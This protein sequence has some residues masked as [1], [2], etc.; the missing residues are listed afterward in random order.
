MSTGRSVYGGNKSFWLLSIFLLLMVMLL[1]LC[2]GRYH[3]PIDKVLSILA[4]SLFPQQWLTSLVPY[5]PIEQRVVEYIR[6]P[7]MLIALLTGAGLSVAGAALQGIFRN[8]LVGPQMVGVSSGAALGGALGIVLF[9]SLLVVSGLAFIGGFG[10]ILLVYFLSRSGGSTS[11][12]MLILAG[13]VISAFF[14]A[15]ISLVTYFADPNNTLPAIVFWLMGSF[16]TVTYTKLALATLPVFCGL[17]LLYAL[18]FR[19]NVLSLGD[20]NAAALGVPVEKVRWLVLICVALIT[21]ATVAVA[22]TIGWVGLVVPH[23]ARMLVGPDH[24]QLIP[25]SALV[26]AIYMVTI[27]TLART[28]SSAEIPLGIITALIGAPVFIWL[29]RQTGQKGWSHD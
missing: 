24:R 27:D 29:L 25:A 18:R 19:I 4:S 2:S 1:A 7:R 21:S 22:G 28:A 12:L 6:L 15:L 9:S 16:A 23:I 17:L 14:A 5:S 11:I 3:L 13:V 20:E 26:G 8:P 10:A